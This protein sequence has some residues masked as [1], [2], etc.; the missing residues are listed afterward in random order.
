[1]KMLRCV[2][3]L[4]AMMTAVAGCA[5]TDTKAGDKLRTVTVADLEAAKAQADATN[6]PQA[7]L[8]YSK[9]IDFVNARGVTTGDVRG[10]FSA[11]QTARSLRRGVDQ[12]IPEDL[13]NACAPLVVD[14]HITL[15]KLGL[16]A[17]GL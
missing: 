5:M 7:S 1:M 6:D 14:A 11:F 17:G 12:G 8:C 15:L 9:V 2:V 10:V 4:M 13:H 3:V 16:I